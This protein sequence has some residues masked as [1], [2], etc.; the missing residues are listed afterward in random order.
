MTKLRAA[1]WDC[2][3]TW[4][5]DERV[6][7]VCAAIAFK[8]I[9]GVEMSHEDYMRHFFGKATS[10]EDTKKFLLEHEYDNFDVIPKV[11]AYEDQLYVE[12]LM[13]GHIT[14]RPGVLEMFHALKDHGCA[15]AIATGAQRAHIDLLWELFDLPPVDLAVTSDNVLYPK[16]HEETFRQAAMGL[17]VNPAHAVGFD[18]SIVGVSSASNAGICAVGITDEV[19]TSDLLKEALGNAGALHIGPFST[20]TLEHVLA[21]HQMHLDRHYSSNL[22]VPALE[23]SFGI[24]FN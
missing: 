10:I 15:Q 8:E 17:N 11:F 4:F 18:D 3:G 16:P 24:T 2:N 23:R 12:M 9:C 6:Y 14:V 1:I 22:E 13:T 7:E 21:A 5:N 19:Y 20:M